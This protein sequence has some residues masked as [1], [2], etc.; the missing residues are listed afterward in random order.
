MPSPGRDDLLEIA[1]LADETGLLV[2]SDEIYEKLVFDGMQHHSMAGM[3]SLYERTVTVNGFSKAY[4]MTGWRVGYL[5]A[6]HWFM[7]PAI[8]IKHTLSIC[9]PPALQRGALA[10]LE[11]G[12][13]AV[14][15][16]L[17]RYQQRLE[18][19]LTGLD[20]L[21]I[22]YG[23]PGGG[24]YVY[25]NI[26]STGMDAETFCYELLRQ[27]QVM[28][29]PGTMFADPANQHVRITLL[30][31]RSSIAEALARMARFIGRL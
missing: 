30:S 31:P 17:E 25:A 29:F 13:A 10:A 16:M 12:D 26:S 24:M 9:T 15:G 22:T 20:G 28:I 7:E 8:E 6:P 23:R 18:L 27:E 1:E 19:I 11:Q 3:A 21:G 2:I 5:A 4:A 14:A